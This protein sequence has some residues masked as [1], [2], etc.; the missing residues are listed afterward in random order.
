M[1]EQSEDDL[2]DE[3]EQAISD[4]I[5]MDWQPIWAARAILP[6]IQAR[7]AAAKERAERLAEALGELLPPMPPKDAIC[8]VGITTQE[9]CCHCSR[10]A[11]GHSALAA[12]EKSRG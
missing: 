2:I 6:I 11:R 4:S 10:I 1:T 12:W 9:N 7:E 8:H 5:D 3:L